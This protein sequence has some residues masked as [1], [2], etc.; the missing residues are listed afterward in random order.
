M[1]G[2][3][4][5]LL[6]A[7]FSVPSRAQASRADVSVGYS[8]A[9]TDFVAG[10]RSLDGFEV[11]YTVKPRL[12]KQWIGLVVD[13]SQYF[14][15][16][17]IP[18]AGACS[19]PGCITPI[20]SSDVRMFNLHYGVRFSGRRDKLEP[21]AKVLIGSSW[22][23]ANG[24]RS[25]LG[26]NQSTAGFSYITGLGVNYNLSRRVGWMFEGDLLQTHLW[27]SF[28]TD[29]RFTTGLVF[30]LGMAPAP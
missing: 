1:R 26:V 13:V 11:D 20:V 5:F 30:F 17:P 23:V 12:R 4:C 24:T 16:A 15:S 22:L 10:S 9:H 2:V 28:Q 7:A 29:A 21:Y 3:L 19:V 25:F 14:G 8:L 18:L 6:I 27:A